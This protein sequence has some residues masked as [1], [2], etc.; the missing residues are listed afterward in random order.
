MNMGL[1]ERI[2]GFVETPRFISKI[3]EALK[4][5]INNFL[6]PQPSN[7]SSTGNLEDSPL[8]AL[9][10]ILNFLTINLGYLNTRRLSDKKPLDKRVG[11][12]IVASYGTEKRITLQH[13]LLEYFS[14]GLRKI[15]IDGIFTNGDIVP[16][17]D[18]Y[19]LDEWYVER[20]AKVRKA[21]TLDIGIKGVENYKIKDIKITE[22]EKVR[23][24]TR[25]YLPEALPFEWHDRGYLKG[26]IEVEGKLLREDPILVKWTSH[27]Y[28]Y[29]FCLGNENMQFQDIYFY[30]G[31]HTFEVHRK[32][33]A[34]P[35]WVANRGELFGCSFDRVK[36][37][38]YGIVSDMSDNIEDFIRKQDIL[39]M[40]MK[41]DFIKDEYKIF[42]N[43]S[44]SQQDDLMEEYKEGL[45][46]GELDM[47][48]LYLF[49]GAQ[50]FVKNHRSENGGI[51]A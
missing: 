25:V 51:T 48:F 23:P 17:S 19:K 9:Y 11:K 4:N 41:N 18:N 45:K 44:K 6:Y 38:L 15:G 14:S 34:V 39:G 47:K 28:Q 13:R 16:S 21:A 8:Y 32:D 27:T 26:T 43:L 22:I 10:S 31:E 40:L 24:Q 35:Y 33:L 36:H 1:E 49:G 20:I 12:S 2:E 37:L 3:G 7:P 42:T 5:G 29:S 46:N 30:F 50:Y